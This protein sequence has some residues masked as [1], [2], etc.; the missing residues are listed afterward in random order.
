M[1]M[2]K[3]EKIWLFFG[4]ATLLVFLI[5]VGISAFYMGNQ[6]PS[7]AVTL[8]PEKVHEWPPF[9][10]PG[11]KQIGENEYQFTIVA[12]AFNFDVG[13]SDRVVQIPKDAV[14]HFNVTTA[15]VV[16]GFELAGTNV[17]MMLEPGY[18][19]TFT[20]TFKNAGVFT[21]LCNEYCGTGHHLM[22]ATIE[23]IE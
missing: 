8:D 10:D 15:D 17:N 14:V 6:P 21:L 22:S 11:L 20:N 16:H 5:V 7:C 1:N 4:T 12:S 2:H 9:D 13:T 19:S 23:V 18:I 3:Y